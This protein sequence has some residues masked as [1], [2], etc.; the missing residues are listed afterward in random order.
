MDT[1]IFQVNQWCL[2]A[3]LLTAGVSK[4]RYFE[5]FYRSVSELLSLSVKRATQFA[6]VIVFGELL[7]AA[8]LLFEWGAGH[9]VGWTVTTLL[10][11]F[12][13]LLLFRLLR[14][15]VVRCSCFGSSDRPVSA[16]DIARNTLLIASAIT[17]SVSGWQVVSWD[18]QE[19]WLALAVS[20]WLTVILVYLHEI[21]SLLLGRFN[22]V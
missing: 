11:G 15:Q 12:T 1:V 3:V 17:V 2:A 22:H 5:Q 21:V 7:L 14:G 6:G 13:A 9:Y 20:C 19:A 8:C 4:A 10:F 16:I 18:N